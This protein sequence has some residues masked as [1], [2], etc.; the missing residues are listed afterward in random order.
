M[1][2]GTVLLSLSLGFAEPAPW[3]DTWPAA[4]KIARL[5]KKPI[6]AVLH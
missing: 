1:T 5:D 6:F 4:Q 3:L 2:L